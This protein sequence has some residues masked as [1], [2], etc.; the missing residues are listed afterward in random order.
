MDYKRNDKVKTI[1]LQTLRIQFEILGMIE[2][3]SV[4]QFMTKVMGIVNQLRINGEKE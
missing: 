2:L 1:R 4:D 3:E